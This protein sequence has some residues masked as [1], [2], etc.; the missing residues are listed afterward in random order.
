MTEPVTVVDAGP[1]IHLDEL[2][3]LDLMEGFGTIHVPH[4]VKEEI[5]IHR[6]KLRLEKLP[7]LQIATRPPQLSPRVAACAH[8]LDL[9]SG[10]IAALNW[11]LYLQG[12]L[13]LSDD[14]AARLAAESLGFQVHGSVGIIVRAI[15]RGR[16]SPTEVK[17]LLEQIP[18]RSTLHINSEL[19]RRVIRSL[20]S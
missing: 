19:L 16:R 2:D 10:E 20:P 8:A 14:W 7:N 15:R 4:E 17:L 6:P 1:V 18:L 13:L 3:C 5:A 12:Q 11:L 9:A